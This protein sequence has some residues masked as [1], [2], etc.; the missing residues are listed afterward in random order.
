MKPNPQSVESF[1]IGGHGPTG[2]GRGGSLQIVIFFEQF[3]M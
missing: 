3:K 2:Q 1:S